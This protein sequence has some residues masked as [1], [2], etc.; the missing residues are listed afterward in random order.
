MKRAKILI[1]ML[2][3]APMLMM[4]GCNKEKANTSTMRFKLT[5]APGAYD[6]VNID[7][8]GVKVF[9]TT[10]GWVTFSSSLGVVNILDYTNGQTTLITEGTIDAGTITQAQLILG[11]NNSVV[12]GGQT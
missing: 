7:I 11:S 4:V 1:L 6:A 5:D 12:V 3:A 9:S 2:V 10:Q 8:Q